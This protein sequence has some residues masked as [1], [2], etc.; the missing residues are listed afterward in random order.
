MKR[1]SIVVAFAVL[2]PA[3]QK[4]TPPPAPEPRKIGQAEVEAAVVALEK[5]YLTG[6]TAA[7]EKFFDA[8]LLFTRETGQIEPRDALVK[9]VGVRPADAPQPE[10]TYRDWQMRQIGNVVI[11]KYNY[12]SNLAGKDGQERSFSAAATWVLEDRDGALVLLS[13]H[14]TE[15]PVREAVAVAQSVLDSYTGQYEDTTAGTTWMLTAENGKLMFGPA[16]VPDLKYEIRAASEDEF[17]F[18][19]SRDTLEFLKDE[20]GTVTGWRYHISDNPPVEAKKLN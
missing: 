10:T 15:V 14:V 17:F 7:V 9:M 19:G 6:D 18:R 13:G 8:E 16:K 20:S 11:A 1:F 2:T 4:A 12:Q 5:A 3:C